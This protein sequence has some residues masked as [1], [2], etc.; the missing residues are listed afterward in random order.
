MVSNSE[1]ITK[2]VT[3]N[4]SQYWLYNTTNAIKSQKFRELIPSL[5]S[6]LNNFRIK[7]SLIATAVEWA[8]RFF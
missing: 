7:T 2:V 3:N 5:K 4:P 1:I 8:K 6:N